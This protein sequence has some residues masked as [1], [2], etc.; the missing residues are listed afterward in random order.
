MTVDSCDVQFCIASDDGL[1]YQ[2]FSRFGAGLCHLSWLVT[3]VYAEM[4]AQ[5]LFV[6]AIATKKKGLTLSTDM[7]VPCPFEGGPSALISQ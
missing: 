6:T 7:G 3:C 5:S 1:A 2:L 4:G